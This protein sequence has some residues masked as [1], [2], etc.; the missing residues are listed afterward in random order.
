MVET[1]IRYGVSVLP[2]VAF[3][4]SLLF[5]DSYKLI[6]F[7]S[8]AAVVIFGVAAAMVSFA[9]GSIVLAQSG[10]AFESY[11][12]WIAPPLE[13]SLKLCYIGWLIRRRRIGF[14]VDAAICGFALGTGFAIFEN[15]YYLRAIATPNVL[16]WIIRG[17]GTA[18]MHGG[19][20]ALAGIIALGFI[21][22]ERARGIAALVPGLA[23]ATLIHSLYNY[24]FLNPVLSAL[25]VVVALPLVMMVV[26]QQSERGLRAWLGVG[27]D[28][29]S[30]L[31]EMITT[32]MIAETRIGRYLLSLKTR[33]PGEAVADMLCLV[34]L[35]VELALKAK[36]ILLM[37]EADFDVKPD[38]E[39]QEKFNEMRYLEKSIGRTGLLAIEP[40]LH[41]SSRDLWQLHMLG[42]K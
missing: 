9:I 24:G 22:R 34:R 10:I 42:R 14:M 29:D 7:R 19:T 28:S 41:W 39:V 31:L 36:G 37:R 38:P 26:F 18:V 11:R 35:H 16:L 5:L 4:V 25:C 15:V 2:V 13:E 27:F 3:L 23:A 12:R 32:G 1:A 33:F 8:V 30:Q 21:E 40:V 17:F 6:R 20:T